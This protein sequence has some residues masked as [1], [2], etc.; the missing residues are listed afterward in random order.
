MLK[1]FLPDTF[2]M[3]NDTTIAKEKIFETPLI[4]LYFSALWC[5][6]CVG[7]HLKLLE[8]YKTVNTPKKR[9]EL[10]LC[11]LDEDEEDFKQYLAK[12]SF[13]AIDYSDPKLEDLIE[14]FGVESI[15]MIVVF[16]YKG[17]LI[18]AEGKHA[19]EGK[20]NLSAEETIKTWLKKSNE[21]IA[22]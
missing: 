11:S 15:P 17:N 13:P 21:K 5:P 4:G 9:I 6:P 12:M 19:V 22:A 8:F 20:S 16:D 1:K 3:S 14:A 18:D 7:F 10:I 2:L